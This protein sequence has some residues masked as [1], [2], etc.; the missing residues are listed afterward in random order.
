MRQIGTGIVILFV[1]ISLGI[2]GLGYLQ[3]NQP[4]PQS[5]PLELTLTIN[6]MA[7]DWMSN[8]VAQ[9]NA[10]DARY[11]NNI[12][13]TITLNP[14]PIED[15]AVWSGNTW[16]NQN[17]PDLWLAST[18]ASIEHANAFSMTFN[19]VN[20]PLAQTPLV[21]VISA[22]VADTITQNGALPLDWD[23]IQ[24]AAS[25]GTWAN[26]GATNLQGNVNM[27]FS[28]P[29]S[30]IEGLMVLYSANAYYSRNLDFSNLLSVP[31]DFKTWFAPMIDSVPNF[32]T[33]GSN[34][35]TFMVSRGTSVNIGIMPEVKLLNQIDAF[36]RNRA[37]R[38]AYP[39][40]PSVFDFSLALSIDQNLSSNDN[41]I[42][43]Q[44][45][46]AFVDWLLAPEQQAQLPRYG[47]RPIATPPTP[48]DDLFRKGMDVGV[49]Y[50]PIIR[51]YLT[52]E[53]SAYSRNLM[54]WFTQERTR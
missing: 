45:M 14:T 46:Q 19:S 8:A 18:S 29:D 24:Q 28:L 34:V 50:D 48:N 22:D 40:Y 31:T 41:T 32:N 15:I 25:A 49:Q 33:I 26:F 53:E 3:Q 1:L 47:L 16:N 5:T 54:S 52:G 10:S 23:V 6:P 38:V 12:A 2:V 21:W 39:E 27:A 35:A 43:Q 11:V 7:Q 13:V 30:T 4:E 42:R 51:P 37:I 44:A 17:R 20:T 36:T 9:F